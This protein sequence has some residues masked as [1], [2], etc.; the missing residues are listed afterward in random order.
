M[1]RRN[2]RSSPGRHS[3]LNI[4][5]Q[6]AL[7]ADQDEGARRRRGE[8]RWEALSHLSMVWERMARTDLR[9]AGSCWGRR[10]CATAARGERGAY[11]AGLMSSCR[12]T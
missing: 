1:T 8:G 4:I 10:G 12:A 9:G 5:F 3:L 7:E 11:V 2:R 6:E